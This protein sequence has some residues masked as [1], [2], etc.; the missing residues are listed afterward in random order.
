MVSKNHAVAQLQSFQINPGRDV[1]CPEAMDL[2]NRYMVGV[3]R[4]SDQLCQ[5][6]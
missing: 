5:V 3:D 6:F 2:Y 4:R 1:P